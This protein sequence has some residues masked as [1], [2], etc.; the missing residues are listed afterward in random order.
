M[1]I[2][3]KDLKQG[4]IL[5]KVE[6]LNDLWTVYNLID[7]GDAVISR[8]H[9]RVVFREGSAGERKPMKLKLK[10][11]QVSFHEFSNRLRIKGTI[12]EGPDEY[13]SYGSYHTFN[14]EPRAKLWIIKDKWFRTELK[15][16]EE[17]SKFEEN[18]LIF[19]IAIEK[20]LAT[21]GMMSNF[22]HHKIASI[23]KN[24]PGKRYEQSH[25]NRALKE[26]FSDI[27]RVLEQNAEKKE[28]NLIIVCGPG[29]MRQHFIKFLKENS[30]MDLSSKIRSIR[31]SSGTESAIQEVLKSPELMKI[32]KNVKILQD[33]R[34]VDEIMKVLGKNADLIAIGFEE[35]SNAAM[36]GAIEEL[37][38]T[39]TLIRGASKESKM[40]IEEIINNVENT[41]GTVNILNRQ[42]PP[43]EQLEDFGSLVGILRYKMRY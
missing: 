7:E 35:V 21:L 39:D 3:E 32:K 10:V 24:I 30:K 17:A 40:K 15:R 2:L 37:F 25:R 14:I 43:G 33:A 42:H 12:L 23:K 38:L 27:Q 1:K 20:G 29:H 13:V 22:N 9:R 34:K 5:V 41:G 19:L 28:I 31:A 36:A 8:T 11:E 18:F 16:L 26:F 6:S 4:S